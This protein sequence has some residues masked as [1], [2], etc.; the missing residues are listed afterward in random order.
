M[1]KQTN[2]P[3]PPAPT[4]SLADHLEEHP[5]IQWFSK[6]GQAIL[7]LLLG[8]VI[9]F[10]LLYRFFGGSEKSQ[11]DFYEAESSLLT[12]Q[13]NPEDTQNA[14]DRLQKILKAHPELHAK[15]DGLIAQALLNKGDV[16]EAK[17]FASLA[18]ERTKAENSPY[19]TDFALTTLLI[20]EQKYDEAL[21]QAKALLQKMQ[22][23][24]EK[25]NDNSVL[26]AYN[27]LRIGMLQQQLGAM[28][29]AQQTWKEWIG[30]AEQSSNRIS[31]GIN[32]NGFY[33]LNRA[34]TEGK[35]S[36]FN[37]MTAQ[38]NLEIKK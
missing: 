10:V 12:L 15:Y 16:Q 11:Q 22:A 27:L 7:Y 25:Q 3:S 8:A 30:L 26:F 9:L 28:E 24:E 5:Y 38:E 4:P 34:F 29:D 21:L 19:Y 17:P 1:K 31:S 14:L 36:L 6:N 20:A 33:Q 18:I 13:Q 35:L 2:V 23:Q 37:Y 32:S